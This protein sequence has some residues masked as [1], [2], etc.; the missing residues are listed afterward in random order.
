VENV[1]LA[2]FEQLGANDILFIDS[3][4]VVRTW[5]RDWL[6]FWSEQY[7][8]QAFL[9]FNSAF[10]VVLALSYLNGHHRDTLARVAPV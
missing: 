4:H 7:M 5:S 2:L 1:D 10:E 9:T 8:V 6:W 3:S